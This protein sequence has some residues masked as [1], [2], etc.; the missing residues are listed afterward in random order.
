V[1][2]DYRDFLGALAECTVVGLESQ[3]QSL[4]DVFMK[5]YGKEDV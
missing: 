2:Q 4:E 3:V 1:H 5:Y